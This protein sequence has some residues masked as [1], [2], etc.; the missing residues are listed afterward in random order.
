[1]MK[2]KFFVARLTRFREV[3]PNTDTPARLMKHGI[4]L[5]AVSGINIICAALNCLLC[6]QP[7]S[8]KNRFSSIIISFKFKS[9]SI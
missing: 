3:Q 9:H 2:Y 5:R 8:R 1:M 7:T 6:C 4:M